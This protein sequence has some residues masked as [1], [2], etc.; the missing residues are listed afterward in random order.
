MLPCSKNNERIKLHNEGISNQPL[1]SNALLSPTIPPTGLTKSVTNYL[2]YI[3]C[4]EPSC[5]DVW[6]HFM[7]RGFPTTPLQFTAFTNN[8]TDR[9]NKISD[10]LLMYIICFEPSCLDIWVSLR[11]LD[12]TTSTSQLCMQEISLIICALLRLAS[13][14]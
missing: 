7:M 10:K 14:T 1:L 12:P 4:F 2:M 9:T 3:I 6:V 13:I 5:L 8:S 11:L